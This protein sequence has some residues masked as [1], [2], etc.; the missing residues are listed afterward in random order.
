MT[1]VL[2]LVA[3]VVPVL[4]CLVFPAALVWQ[5]SGDLRRRAAG[6]PAP[7][8]TAGVSGAAQAV[9]FLT[10]GTLNAPWGTV[11]VPLWWLAVWLLALGVVVLALRWRRLAPN[12]PRPRREL[13]GAS[14]WV[15]LAGAL[16]AVV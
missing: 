13:L 15:L 4:V 12:G 1:V 16:L 14:V 7:T 10:V 9:L 8:R 6:R 3:V 5:V 2:D 11:P